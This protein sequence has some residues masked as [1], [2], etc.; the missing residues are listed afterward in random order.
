MTLGEI[1]IKLGLKSEGFSKGI[2]NVK[3]ETNMF[4]DGMKKLGGMIAG[5]FAVGAIKNFIS[6]IINV[7][8]EFEK[9]GA[10]LTNTLGSERQA[11]TDMQMLSDQNNFFLVTERWVYPNFPGGVS[12]GSEVWQYTGCWFSNIGRNY[13]SDGDRI[14]NVNATLMYVRRNKIA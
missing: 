3:K 12:G 14:V 9:Y 4:A 5:V 2:D 13:R 6:N 11:R 1:F 8:S 7:S 10:L